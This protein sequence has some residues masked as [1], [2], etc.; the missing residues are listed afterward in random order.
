[1]LWGG[2]SPQRA[3]DLLTAQEAPEESEQT[4]DAKDFVRSFISEGP[5][6]VGTILKVGKAMGFHERTLQRAKKKLGAKI[7][8]LGYGEHQIAYWHMPGMPPTDN[9]N[10][11]A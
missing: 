7:T 1:M 2:T 5:C 4:T 10:T 9:T 8:R 11:A 6:L 3:D